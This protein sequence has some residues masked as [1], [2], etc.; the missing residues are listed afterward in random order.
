MTTD[1]SERAHSLGAVARAYDVGRPTFPADALTWILGPGRLQVLDF[2]AIYPV[3]QIAWGA[4]FAVAKSALNSATVARLASVGMG[5]L[6]CFGT[7]PACDGRPRSMI[8]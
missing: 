7:R 2:S 4:M 3:T 6:L 8:G 5:A 1:D